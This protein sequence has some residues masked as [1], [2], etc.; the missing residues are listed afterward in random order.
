MG[1][2]KVEVMDIDLALMTAMSLGIL[3]G[4]AKVYL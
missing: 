3:L 1:D 2:E 4:I